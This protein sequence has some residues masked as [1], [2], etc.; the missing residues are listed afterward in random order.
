MHWSPLG[1]K[2]YVC[3]ANHLV[4]LV[5]AKKIGEPQFIN[6]RLNWG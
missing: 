1:T 4:P 2:L 3:I 6:A 5:V